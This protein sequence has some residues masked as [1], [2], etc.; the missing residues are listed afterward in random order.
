MKLL[1]RYVLTSLVQM[2]L[3][4]VLLH[5]LPALSIVDLH[6]VVLAILHFAGILES[7]GEQIA[8]VVVVGSVL[9]A[10]IADIGEIFVKFLCRT[11]SANSD[12]KDKPAH[13]WEAIA[14]VLDRRRLFLLSDFL[15]FLLIGRSLEA[16]PGQATAEEIH[17]NVT[18]CF[19]IVSP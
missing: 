5:V 15:V 1:G 3:R 13:T 8:K 14:K 16:L 11:I 6:P 9:E 18:Q 12:D 2:S 19:E 7:L 17:E 4:W 10:K